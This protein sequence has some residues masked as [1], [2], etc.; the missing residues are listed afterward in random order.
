MR[1]SSPALVTAL[2]PQRPAV[3]PAGGRGVTATRPTVTAPI[4]ASRADGPD[5][6]QPDRHGTDRHQS[7]RHRV[8][9]DQP[10]RHASCTKRL[11]P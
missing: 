2:G 3:I 11:R 9:C 5:G 10:N 6:Q 4:A 7:D 8:Q 1:P